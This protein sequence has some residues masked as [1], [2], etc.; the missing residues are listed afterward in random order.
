[1]VKLAPKEPLSLLY[2]KGFDS[3]WLLILF[4]PTNLTYVAIYGDEPNVVQAFL[5]FHEYDLDSL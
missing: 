1:V 3:T 4:L 5:F 2:I